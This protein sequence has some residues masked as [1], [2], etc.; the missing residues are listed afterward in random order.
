MSSSLQ[1]YTDHFKLREHIQLN[2]EVTKIEKAE[3]YD[4]TGR[5]TIYFRQDRREP[6]KKTFDFIMICSGYFTNPVIP[7]YPGLDDFTG[8]VSHTA[9]Y[10]R[11]EHFE[12]KKVLVI[13]RLQLCPQKY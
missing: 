10:R 1:D 8:S 6:V 4:V 7:P 2:T 13:G 11:R 5:W 12:D 9:Q 3:D